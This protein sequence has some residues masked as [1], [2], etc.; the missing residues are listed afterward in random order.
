MTSARMTAAKMTTANR[1]DLLADLVAR[2]RRRGAD[3][4]D[5]ITIDSRSLSVDWRLGR[6]E[7]LERSESADLGLRVIIG[8]R[9]AIVSSTDFSDQ[10]LVELVG[11][12]ID[13]A[14]AVPEDPYCGLAEPAA[15]ARTIPSLDLHDPV[16]PSAETLT[17]RA[18]AAEDAARAVPGVTNSEGSGASWGAS[19]VAL[20]ASNGFAGAYRGS[21]HSVHASVLAGSGTGMERD[22][23]YSTSVHG[24][25]LEDPAAVG[26]R[27]GE[28]AVKRL[29]P[30][31]VKSARLP[32]VY[33]P[34]VSGGLVRHLANAINGAA[35]AR[36]TSFLKDK[37][38]QR[39]FPA[40]T[41]IVD[42]PLKPRGLAS[43]PFDA[44]GLP[45]ARRR[46]IEDGVLT[47]W[48]LDLRSARQ[49]GLASNGCA[50]RGAGS[51]P[52]PSPANLWL[53]PGTLSPKALMAD[54]AQGLYITELI[55]MGVNGVT[56]DY[57]RGAAGFWIEKGELAYPVSEVTVAG[58]L[59]PMFQ[60]MTVANDLVFRTGC[61]APT[62]RIDG[63][64]I[65]GR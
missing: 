57:S 33:D 20:V 29:D 46:W 42:D 49:L 36:G 39:L 2:A 52:A 14:R 56:G 7:G 41:M 10:A 12:A 27:A 3:E 59:L 31:K 13:M 45:V 63:M 54:I 1:L 22:Y 19:D 28:R 38:G 34:R 15:I 8:K 5:A 21:R 16:E 65:A 6:S 9:Q 25:D 48:I 43:R 24:G 18:S 23:D 47:G 55:G 26:R 51:P 64:T 35:I 58:N 37:L 62:L 50:S 32:V 40:G 4:A 44:E 61:D 17:A 11:R 60:A 53:E 30:R